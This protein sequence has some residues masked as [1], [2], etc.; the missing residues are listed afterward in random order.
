[1]IK[2]VWQEH[3]ATQRFWFNR[4]K[5]HLHFLVFIPRLFFPSPFPSVFSSECQIKIKY[6]FLNNNI[7]ANKM[8]E[9]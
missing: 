8:K 1:M 7:D 6:T 2:Y 4:I 9:K 5:S 3:I